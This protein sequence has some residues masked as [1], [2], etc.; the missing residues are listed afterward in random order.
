MYRDNEMMTLCPEDGNALVVLFNVT[1]TDTQKKN[2]S[3]GLTQN[4][5]E[6]GL[7]TPELPDTISPFIA[8][9]EVCKLFSTGTLAFTHCIAQVQAHFEA[10]N[11]A[12]TLDLIRC[13]WGY[14]LTTNLL[15]Q[16][17][18]LEGFTTNGFL[19]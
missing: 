14:M 15:V 19:L 17:T 9:F 6:I 1:L 2:V 4:W 10:G 3:D 18:L 8:G 11:D 7:V 13:T 12:R 5:N 16:S